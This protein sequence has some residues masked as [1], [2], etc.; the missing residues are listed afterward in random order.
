MQLLLELL[1]V[2]VAAAHVSRRDVLEE[3]QHGE[4]LE[5]QLREL[6]ELELAVRPMLAAV[7]E[8]RRELWRPGAAVTL[9]LLLS[10]IAAVCVLTCVQDDVQDKL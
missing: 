2:V 6:V 10:E 5:R 4:A 8:E 7:H 9:L 1:N 3:L